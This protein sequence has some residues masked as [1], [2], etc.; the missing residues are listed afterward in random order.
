MR[1]VAR[2]RAA[3]GEPSSGNTD[4]TAFLDGATIDRGLPLRDQI[5]SLVRRAIVTG[6][7]S[8]GAS[9]NEIAV[10]ERL[11]IS[12][13]PVR[14]AVKKVGDEGLINVRAQAGTFVA[15]ISRKQV[16]EAYVIRIALERESVR[17]AAEVITPA[18]VQSLRDLIELHERSVRRSKFE[19]AIDH[20]DTFHRSIADINGYS[21]LWKVVDMSKAQMDRCRLLALPSP[22]AGE[23]TIEQHHA[24]V[25]ALE[26]HDAGK[27]ERA[28]SE[29]LETSLDNTLAVLD[30]IDVRPLTPAK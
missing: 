2:D 1:T 16:S 13:T 22:G 20:D 23:T 15:P 19:D 5:Y 27:A 11:G 24:I 25:D 3:S 8:P 7:L 28:I 21:M 30:K 9:I 4:P 12:R 14:E 6:R 17:H 10:A 26:A 18:Q 29:H